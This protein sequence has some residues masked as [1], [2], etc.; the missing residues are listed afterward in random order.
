MSWENASKE[1]SDGDESW[2]ELENL[3]RKVTWLNDGHDHTT[4]TNGSP[5]RAR[6]GLPAPLHLGLFEH[7]SRRDGGAPTGTTGRPL[8]SLCTGPQ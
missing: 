1:I 4:H 3:L 5:G 8:A 6:A 2:N 7:G